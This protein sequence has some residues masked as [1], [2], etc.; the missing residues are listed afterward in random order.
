MN[1]TQEIIKELID[2]NPETG[3]CFWKER[4]CKHFIDGEKHNSAT[5]AK[6]W[7]C[8]YFGKEINGVN[9]GRYF[10]IRLFRKDYKLHRVIWLYMTGEWPDQVDHI[11]GDRSN[12]KW[13][14]LRNVNRS[15]NLRN[16]KVRSTNTS[17]VMGVH[18]YK[19]LCK[20]VATIYAENRNI[21]LGYF[22]CIAHAVRARKEAEVKYGF[23]PNHGRK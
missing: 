22:S 21:H 20:W 10:R 14:N 15:Q 16:Q 5:K 8:K 18:W 4:S 11:D 1:I 19:N 23:H 3:R 12:N 6:I 9:E 7:N 17:G 2:Y 13:E